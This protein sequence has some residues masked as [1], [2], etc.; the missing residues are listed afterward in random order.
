MTCRRRRI[1]KKR[2]TLPIAV[3]GD[4]FIFLFI[5]PMGTIKKEKEEEED[6]DDD[7][8]E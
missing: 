6:D 4:V 8:N 1:K 2:V 3:Q 7:D 5:T